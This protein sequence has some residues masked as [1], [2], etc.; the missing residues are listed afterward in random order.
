MKS[1][2]EIELKIKEME[3]QREEEQKQKEREEKGLS[4]NSFPID[5][6]M[7]QK[8]LKTKRYERN[9]YRY[10]KQKRIL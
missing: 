5:Q 2:Y 10:R 1:S 3:K 4:I 8:Q 6:K 7:N 9:N